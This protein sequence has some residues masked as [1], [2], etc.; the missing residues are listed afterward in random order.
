MGKAHFSRKTRLRAI[1]AISFIFF[2]AEL[3]CKLERPWIQILCS[4]I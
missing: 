3:S 2:L 1:I 4:D